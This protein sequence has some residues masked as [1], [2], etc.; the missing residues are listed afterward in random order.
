MNKYER[1]L[2]GFYKYKKRLRNYSSRGANYYILK[3]TGKPCSC[4]MCSP[5]KN[6]DKAK[7]Q[8]KLNKAHHSIRLY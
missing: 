7:Y 5:K 3:T 4:Y 1:R 2:K 8:E 6:E